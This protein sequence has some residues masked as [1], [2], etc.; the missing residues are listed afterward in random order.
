MNEC[1]L[2]CDWL[3]RSRRHRLSF[4]V[5]TV[6]TVHG[7]LL[8]TAR[9]RKENVRRGGGGGGGADTDLKNILMIDQDSLS[10]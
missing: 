4:S 3:E 9:E 10:S 6:T 8:E 1:Q 5:L 2:C 7:G